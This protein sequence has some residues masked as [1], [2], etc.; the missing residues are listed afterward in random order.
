MCH[1]QSMSTACSSKHSGGLSHASAWLLLTFAAWGGCSKDSKTYPLLWNVSLENDALRSRMIAVEVTVLRDGCQGTN[2]V[3]EQWVRKNDMPVKPPRLGSGVFAFRARAVDGTC[4][5]FAS[6]CAEIKLP[7]ENQ[8]LNL[9]MQTQTEQALCTASQCNAGV[10]DGATGDGGV[11]G[12]S[13]SDSGLHMDS[14]PIIDSGPVVDSG[15]I[16]SGTPSIDSGSDSG[17]DPCTLLVEACDGMNNDCDSNI[18][19]GCCTPPFTLARPMNMTNTFRCYSAEQP[20]TTEAQAMSTCAGMGATLDPAP[21]G[22][23]GAFHDGEGQQC[24]PSSTTFGCGVGP[25]VCRQD[26]G[27]QGASGCTSCYL[28]STTSC[29]LSCVQPYFCTKPPLH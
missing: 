26:G 10:C 13:G 2:V 22:R 24:T 4:T 17:P 3:Y 29:A 25:G 7:A 15:P 27:I 23:C 19:E 11:T 8:E 18:D 6:G 21:E 5:A 20:A 28:P 1:R 12:D 14:G 9:V 16:D